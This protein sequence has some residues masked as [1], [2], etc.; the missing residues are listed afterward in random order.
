MTTK[1]KIEKGIIRIENGRLAGLGSDENDG[2]NIELLD[3]LLYEVGK[4]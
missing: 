3:E 4:S 1:E 2:I